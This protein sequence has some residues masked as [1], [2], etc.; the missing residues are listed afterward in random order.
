MV[1]KPRIIF[2][3]IFHKRFFPKVN[4]FLYNSFYFLIPLDSLEKLNQ[5]FMVRLNKFWFFSFYPKDHC[6]DENLHKWF[7]NLLKKYNVINKNEA[8]S[9]SLMAMPRVLGYVFNPVSFWFCFNNSNK[10]IA[11]LSEVR[12]TYGEKH[13]YL[14]YNYDYS[15]INN[16]DILIT[17]KIFHVSPFIKRSGKYNFRFAMEEKNIGVWID[18]L[19]DSTK[20]IIATS[21][22]GKIVDYNNKNLVYSFVFFPFI[23]LKTIILIHWQALK[24]FIKGIKYLNKPK[25][26]KTKLSIA[27]NKKH[28]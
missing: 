3:R 2:A 20:K 23:T 24:L 22:V 19:N 8:V 12:N 14:C 6:P 15:P 5:N 25:Q 18:L 9:I 13:S 11:V 4:Q 26:L 10:L 21:I 28:D 17:K 1:D 7:K 27:L 16:Q